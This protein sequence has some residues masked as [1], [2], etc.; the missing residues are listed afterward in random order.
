MPESQLHVFTNQSSYLGQSYYTSP[1]QVW[2]QGFQDLVGKLGSSPGACSY[3]NA[4]QEQIQV[5]VRG[6]NN[7][8]WQAFWDGSEW[9]G[10]FDFDEEFRESPAITQFDN[11]GDTQ[12]HVFY[13]GE[14]H[15][16]RQR[17]YGAGGWSGPFDLPGQL[18]SSPAATEYVQD[19]Q[20][21]LHVFFKGPTGMLCQLFYDGAWEGPFELTGPIHSA[22]AVAPYDHNGQLELHVFYRTS[23]GSVA[24]YRYVP[25]VGWQ[26]P[27]DHGGN[28][29]DAPGVAAY[30]NSGQTQLHVFG[31]G[32]N[33]HLTQ[34]FFDGRH[35]YGWFDLVESMSGAPAVTSYQ[36]TDLEPANVLVTKSGN[37]P[38]IALSGKTL[39]AAWN[40]PGPPRQVV[41]TAS[42]G[43]LQ[44]W[45]QGTS[46]TPVGLQAW[47]DT[48]LARLGV[49]GGF[50]MTFLGLYPNQT[51]L[52]ILTSRTGGRAGWSTAVNVSNAPADSGDKPLVATRGDLCAVAWND[53][54]VG[55]VLFSQS[56]DAGQS[57]SRPVQVSHSNTGDAWRWGAVPVLS[58]DG[59]IY[60]VWN[61]SRRAPGAD[62]DGSMYFAVSTDGG[63]SF[64]EKAIDAHRDDSPDMNWYPQ[65]PPTTPR[66]QTPPPGPN[67][68]FRLKS[69]VAFAQNPANGE[70]YVAWGDN[71]F[72]GTR[73]RPWDIVFTRS[74]NQGRSWLK[75]RRV[76]DVQGKFH[77]FPWL[78]CSLD[79]R[80]D[81]VYCSRRLTVHDNGSDVFCQS[82]WDG[83]VNW[84]RAQRVS[85]G[86]SPIIGFM[87]D[88][89]QC[90][91]DDASCYPV[92]TDSRDNTIAVYAAQLARTP[93]PAWRPIP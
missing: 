48:G 2:L 61:D 21:Q 14:A 68:G 89:I 58:D 83:G 87:G 53:Y 17:F 13:Q 22:P 69:P 70:L 36:Q 72:N 79:G 82:S 19:D 42:V 34:R 57:W 56:T 8:L 92:W 52:D 44:N 38:S 16:L 64:K 59:R 80:L 91:S 18:T 55:Q 6:R 66:G 71:R 77:Y 31:R 3:L 81:L 5:F 86:T 1:A 73:K 45:T 25:G 37:E 65:Q 50:V 43:N 39:A 35:W 76:S 62:V 20:T 49:D 63:R 28:V 26:G 12:L 84:T 51:S 7:H 23:R 24:Q 60:V 10:W 85:T 11:E 40:A 67:G 32:Q 41:S 27:F 88:Y 4:G 46:T 54:T 9:M 90:V 75:T 93:P 15:Q 33:H 47:G 78:S 29:T 74:K 30:T